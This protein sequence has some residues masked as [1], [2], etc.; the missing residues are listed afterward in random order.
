MNE[1]IILGFLSIL[2]FS[3]PLTNNGNDNLNYE[4]NNWSD[5]IAKFGEPTYETIEKGGYTIL[6]FPGLIYNGISDGYKQFVSTQEDYTFA[7]YADEY[8]METSYSF[9]E[10]ENHYEELYGVQ[11]NE[12]NSGNWLTKSRNFECDYYDYS[13]DAD[14][15]IVVFYRNNQYVSTNVG[16]WGTTIGTYEY[17]FDEF[18]QKAVK[19]N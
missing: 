10:L 1:Y 18:N 2:L 8:V 19:W 5:E 3:C 17:I 7:I 9:E 4:G 11:C 13:I 6:P 14:Y 16:V 15:K 12:F